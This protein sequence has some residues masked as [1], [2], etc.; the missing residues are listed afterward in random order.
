MSR[1]RFKGSTSAS[2]PTPPLGKASLYYD[3]S[4][5]S[6]KMKL[7]NGDILALGITEEYIRD[8]VGALLTNSSTIE[9][10]YDDLADLLTLDLK[11]SIINDTYVD[12]I[13]PTKIIDAQNG[14]YEAT[15]ITNDDTLTPIF[16]LDCA[17]DGCWMVEL[18]LTARRLGGL[19][20][21]SGDGATFKRTFR[22][23]SIGSSVTIHDIQSDYTSRDAAGINLIIYPNS[24]N[25]VVSVQGW[26]NN[27]IRWN[28]DII[29]SINN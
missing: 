19:A 21:N 4:D 29:V 26:P 6:L 15:L 7:D 18:R 11:T 25:A 5:K 3:D 13:S 23:K 1:I 20:G 10:N 24:T 17:V 14:R 16:A 2:I 27:N 8:I 12:K 22:V 9:A 28:A